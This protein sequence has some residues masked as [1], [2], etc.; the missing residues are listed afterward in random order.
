[1]LLRTDLSRD[2]V[3]SHQDLRDDSG[4]LQTWSLTD[5]GPASRPLSDRVIQRL[6]F[7][8]PRGSKNMACRFVGGAA[9]V[10]EQGWLHMA[11]HARVSLN[12]YLNSF[13]ENYWSRHA[14]LTE[15][16]LALFGAGEVEVQA[17]R[18]S[19]GLAGQI[20][21]VARTSLVLNDA[22]GARLTIELEPYPATA[23][24]IYFQLKALSDQAVVTAGL[25]EV[26]TPPPYGR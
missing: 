25:Y 9:M 15:V 16:T 26:G 24:R 8:D 23:G 4:G 13:Y 19:P 22:A 17:F 11:R 14:P 3:S 5:Q 10:D 1:M 18:R 20:L 7:N 6:R 21:R 12:T 2:D